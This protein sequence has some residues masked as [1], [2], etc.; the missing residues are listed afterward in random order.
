MYVLMFL[1]LFLFDLLGVVGA[2]ENFF[3]GFGSPLFYSLLC[4]LL[5]CMTPSYLVY[6]FQA[7]AP[8][9]ASHLT[10]GTI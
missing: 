7:N 3:L 5:G 1:A 2:K 10:A 6:K 9:S 8:V 4:L